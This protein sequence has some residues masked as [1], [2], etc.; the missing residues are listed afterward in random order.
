MLT[1]EKTRN[2]LGHWHWTSIMGPK[3]LK[4]ENIS[5]EVKRKTLNLEPGVCLVWDKDLRVAKWQR[6]VEQG[7]WRQQM[8]G[9]S[10]NRQ[11]LW[12]VRQPSAQN[13]LGLGDVG[14]VHLSLSS[15]LKSYLGSRTPGK[16]RISYE[17]AL[18]AWNVEIWGNYCD[19]TTGPAPS[20]GS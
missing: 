7:W 12:S 11:W 15:H 17:W 6:A 16:E 18:R 5:K 13:R 3:V 1:E 2:P 20:W 4:S 14:T 19:E 8:P 10:R 9:Q